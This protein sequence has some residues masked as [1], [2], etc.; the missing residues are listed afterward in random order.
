MMKQRTLFNFL[1]ALLMF[2]ACSKNENPQ[3]DPGPTPPDPPTPVDSYFHI[4]SEADLAHFLDTTSVEF[5]DTVVFD[6]DITVE[7]TLPCGADF[8]GV[9]DGKGHTIK[10]W[11]SSTSLFAVNSGKICNLNV[12]GRAEGRA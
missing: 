2:S 12:D 10:N 4:A 11:K 7:G 1:A 9:L 8:S 3:P 5:T 6:N